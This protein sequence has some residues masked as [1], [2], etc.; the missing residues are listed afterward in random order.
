MAIHASAFAV[1]L[2]FG[3]YSGKSLG[4]IYHLDKS[5]LKWIASTDTIPQIWRDR[6]L[7]TLEGKE[8]PNTPVPS[9][10]T[11]HEKAEFIAGK[12]K[13]VYVTFPY[14]EVLIERFKYEIDAKQWNKEEKRW[15]VAAAQLPKLV[16]FFGGKTKINPDETVKQWYQEEI[17]RRKALD[18]IRNQTDSDVN[19]KTLVPLFPY[20]RVAIEFFDRANGRVLCADQMGTGKTLMAIAYAIHKNAKTLIICPKSVK[21][22]WARE[23]LRFA[24]KTSCIWDG[25]G[26]EAGHKNANFHIINYDNVVKHIKYFREAGFDLLVCDEAT[27][28][29]NYQS[30]RTKVIFGKWNERKKYPGIKTKYVLLLTGTPILNRT[31]EA[32]TLLSFLSKDRFNNPKHFRMRYGK[33]E[34]GNPQ[35]LDELYHRTQDLVIRRLKSQVDKELPPKQRFD[36]MVEMTTTEA[37]AYNK[38][39]E[40]LFKKWKLLGNP[41]AAHMPAIRHLLFEYKWPRITEFIDEMLDSERSLLVFAIHPAHVHKIKE[42]YGDVCRVI[43][44]TTSSKDREAAIADLKAGKAKLGAFTMNATGMGIDG[45]Q[46]TIDAALFVDR[47]FVPAIHEQAEDRIHRRGQKKQVQIWYMTVENTIDQIMA[48]ILAEKQQIIDQAVDG[49]IFDR[50]MSKSIF[51]EVVRQIQK[52]YNVYFEGLENATETESF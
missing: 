19:V 8:I 18:E 43:D 5:Y 30:T 9:T 41:S 32:F 1:K 28:L 39:L 31:E 46:E 35:N 3:K 12:N 22:N 14:N 42:K 33:D 48:S 29:K 40:E 45:L 51:K 34:F 21:F 23:I 37:K 20:Q 36:L 50:T 10:L 13:K 47:W 6:C 24:G 25:K 15:E 49:A 27:Y 11:G 7:L 17:E 38:K 44:G 2:S 52:Q 26:V 16:E 4:E